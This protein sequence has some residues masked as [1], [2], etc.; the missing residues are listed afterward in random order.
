MI[1]V[2][3]ALFYVIIALALGHLVYESIIAP[4][5]RM[6]SRAELLMSKMKLHQHKY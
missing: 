2:M 3:A 4:N 6:V 1:S 5:K